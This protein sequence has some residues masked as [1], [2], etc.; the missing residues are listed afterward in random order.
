MFSLKSIPRTNGAA[1]GNCLF[2][3]HS[4]SRLKMPATGKN[5]TASAMTY[6]PWVPSLDIDTED[7]FPAL[8]WKTPSDRKSFPCLG[9]SCWLMRIVVSPRAWRIVTG[10]LVARLT[11]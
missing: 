11:L 2:F 8:N 7:V 10:V 9:T 5:C 6:L 3:T 1:S 4:F